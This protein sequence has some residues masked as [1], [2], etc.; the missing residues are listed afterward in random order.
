MS[1]TEGVSGENASATKTGDSYQ[2]TGTAGGG[3]SFAVT[4]IRLLWR[5]V[6]I[7]WRRPREVLMTSGG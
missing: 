6:T 5:S 2:I 4:Q 1:F 3:C 7:R